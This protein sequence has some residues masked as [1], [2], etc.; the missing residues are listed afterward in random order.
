MSQVRK[1]QAKNRLEKLGIPLKVI[2]SFYK[3]APSLAGRVRSLS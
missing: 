1:T 3:K 2:F